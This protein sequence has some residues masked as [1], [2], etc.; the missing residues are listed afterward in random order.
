MDELK[1]IKDAEKRIKAI[2]DA[3]E[4]ELSELAEK[5]EK[6]KAAIEAASYEMEKATAAGDVKLYQESKRR[7]TEEEDAQEMYE[8][9]MKTLEKEN[10]ITPE[11]YKK[12]VTEI[13]EAANAYKRA[14]QEEL[15]ALAE[16]MYDTAEKV[17]EVQQAANEV[18]RKLQHDIFRDEDRTKNKKGEPLLI[19]SE[20]QKV[21]YGEV[22]NWGQAAKVS[23]MY[24]SVTGN[25]VELEKPKF[26]I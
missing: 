16:S 25:K 20:D 12:R 6:G 18:L 4:K 14:K 19:S 10:L 3:R 13:K 24:E 8:K 5:I 1:S 22:I 17:R 23:Y 9:R 15:A 21:D 7:R 11:E 26:V 2:K